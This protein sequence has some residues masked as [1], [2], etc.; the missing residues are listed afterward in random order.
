MTASKSFGT[1]RGCGKRILWVKMRSGKNMP[2]DCN[3]VSYQ[4]LNGGN[5][6]IVTQEGDVVVGI[7][8]VSPEESD[9]M[10]YI[11][12]FAT[13]MSIGNFRRKSSGR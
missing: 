5:E 4:K 3:I 9:G 2:C 8:G 12:H 11:S 13:C 6:K 10:G 1:C 7:T